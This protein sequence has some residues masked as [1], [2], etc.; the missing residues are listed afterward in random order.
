VSKGI[1]QL[2]TLVSEPPRGADWVYERKL[3]GYRAM[4]DLRRK[5]HL[6]LTSRNGLSFVEQFPAIAGAL[7]AMPSLR[8][9]V[10]DGE[11]VAYEGDAVSFHAMQLARQHG[12][13]GRLEYVLF[14]LL[15]A[16]GVDV[17]ELPLSERRARLLE[18]VPLGGVVRAIAYE[19]DADAALANARALHDEGILAKLAN[20]PYRS[21]RSLGWQ[22][23]KITTEDDFVVVGWTASK[24]GPAAIGSLAL[25]TRER[26]GGPLVYAGRVGTGFDLAL[27]GDLAARLGRRRTPSP[28]LD[29]PREAARGVAWTEPRMVVRVG[30]LS[31]T[32]DGVLRHPTFRGERRDIAAV[33]VARE[34]PAPSP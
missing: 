8:G 13:D 26:K 33:D 18:R 21:E 9:A 29:V 34:R 31:Y 32:P 23:I 20:A 19:K 3:D 4:G 1:F 30:Y 22:K 12:S 14:D 5:G 24:N 11:I 10:V 7:S 6:A 16:S 2:A 17:R 15:A 28:P 25:A 27:R